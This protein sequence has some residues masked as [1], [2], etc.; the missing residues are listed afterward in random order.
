MMFSMLPVSFDLGGIIQNG[1]HSKSVSS[2][3]I[4]P[5]ETRHK[6]C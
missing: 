6:L 5:W 4:D 3:Y 1:L 2:P